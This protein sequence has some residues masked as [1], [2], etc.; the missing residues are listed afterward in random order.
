[1]A[2][3]I[4]TRIVGSSSLSTLCSTASRAVM[5]DLS[6]HFLDESS[7]QCANKDLSV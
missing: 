7:A 2:H 6:S 1:M 3:A 4:V 5:D